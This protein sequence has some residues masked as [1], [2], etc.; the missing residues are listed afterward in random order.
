MAKILLFFKRNFVVGL[1]EVFLDVF[2]L[3]RDLG[4]DVDAFL[5]AE[6]AALRGAH[7]FAEAVVDAA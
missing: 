7:L 1:V 3:V 5:Q 4:P 2:V 6:D